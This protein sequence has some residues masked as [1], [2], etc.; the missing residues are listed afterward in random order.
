MDFPYLNRADWDADESYRFAPDGS[1]IFPPAYFD[2]QTL[3]VHHTVTANNDADP[4]A[5]V[6]AIYFDMAVTQDFG[7]I[8]YHLLIDQQGTVY[9]G[10]YSGNDSVPV[11]GPRRVGPRPSMVNAAH[12][13]G[14]NAGQRRRR[15]AR[16][17]DQHAAHRGGPRLPGQGPGRAGG[18]DPTG[19]A[20]HDEL[21]EPDQCCHAHGADHRRSPG[22]GRHAVPRQQL[23]SG[24]GAGPRRR[25]GADGVLTIG[26]NSGGC[27]GFR[28]RRTSAGDVVVR[29]V[30][31]DAAEIPL[32]RCAV[33]HMAGN[34]FGVR[35]DLLA[36]AAVDPLAEEVR[37]AVVP[38]VLL[39]HVHDHDA[40]YVA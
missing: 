16:R 23:L 3:T 4:A 18:R 32:R 28:P 40:Q 25:C 24:P 1:E 27:C 26:R 5:T 30:A 29:H 10:R 21:R 22:L 8:G 38:R 14:F 17:S 13:G 35:P 33:H 36:D 15:P 2:V 6:R 39:D 7:D 37:V 11:F 20:G 34:G 12:V 19:S 9:E 31:A